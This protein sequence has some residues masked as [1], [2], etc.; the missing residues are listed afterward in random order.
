ME[1][2]DICLTPVYWGVNIWIRLEESQVSNW[3]VRQNI[4]KLSTPYSSLSHIFNT[5]HH[6]NLNLLLSKHEAWVFRSHKS[7]QELHAWLGARMS[8]QYRLLSATGKNH[9]A[10]HPSP[11]KSMCC[12][13]ATTPS[14]GVTIQAT[15]LLSTTD[16]QLQSYTPDDTGWTTSITV[17]QTGEV[18]CKLP[19]T[20]ITRSDGRT[21]FIISGAAAYMERW[22]GS[23]APVREVS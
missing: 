22:K 14:T 20:A 11:C 13:Q 8:Q 19:K 17:Y 16:E 6:V 2:A 9:G 5:Y 23:S 21:P 3:T 7:L 4:H 10:Q 15:S 18:L 12:S 1:E